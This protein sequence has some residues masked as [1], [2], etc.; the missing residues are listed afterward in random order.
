MSLSIKPGAAGALTVAVLQAAV[1]FASLP[2]SA[3]EPVR[4]MSVNVRPQVLS[5]GI[6]QF[7]PDA[8]INGGSCS[9]TCCAAGV[10][11]SASAQI[12]GGIYYPGNCSDIQAICTAYANIPAEC[13]CGCKISCSNTGGLTSSL[14]GNGI[15]GGT[16]GLSSDLGTT[17]LNGP[18]QG[19]P[20]F[21]EHATTANRQ[22]MQEAEQRYERIEPVRRDEI[23][24]EFSRSFDDNFDAGCSSDYDSCSQAT[25]QS[26]SYDSWARQEY[27]GGLGDAFSKTYSDTLADTITCESVADKVSEHLKEGAEKADKAKEKYD[28]YNEAA[29]KCYDANKKENDAVK[30]GNLIAQNEQVN[31]NNSKLFKCLD[32][33]KD[34]GQAF[35]EDVLG[36]QSGMAKK[37]YDTAKNFIPDYAGKLMARA[38]D[39]MNSTT[40]CMETVCNH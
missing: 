19:L 9:A 4:P 24:T 22:W 20:S 12:P 29:K 6:R 15:T 40:K 13:T 5:V 1:F 37:F 3:A 27:A 14:T 17:R 11:A 39:M 35:G 7:A 31:E 8:M 26:D 28:S 21:T 38:G 18:A 30:E 36:K 10:C 16:G 2:A 33:A 25:Q 23:P 32:A 34:A